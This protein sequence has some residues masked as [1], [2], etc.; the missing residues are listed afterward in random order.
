MAMADGR[1]DDSEG[2]APDNL[3]P[4]LPNQDLA[5]LFARNIHHVRAFV[6]LR[7]DPLTRSRESVSDIVQSACRELLDSERFEFRDEKAFRSYLCQ[8]ALFKIQ[9]R[10]RHHAAAKRQQAGQGP[11]QG[12]DDG[13]A[14]VY[15]TTLF[16]PSRQAIH[17]EEID[18]LERA[19]DQLPEDYRQALSLY[20]IVGLSIAEVAQ[21]TGRTEG[22]TKMLMH[23]AMAR[24]TSILAR[25]ADP[26]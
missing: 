15:R 4:E 5:A 3:P 26:A 21:Q 19:F 17:K 10:H 23:R 6:R 1:T 14:N 25:P 22:A 11:L 13:L 16:D 24:L 8:A 2:R 20:R 12:T 9:N 18:L 7:I